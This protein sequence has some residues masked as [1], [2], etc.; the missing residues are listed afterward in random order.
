MSHMEKIL[1][2]Q[3]SLYYQIWNGSHK[4]VSKIAKLR[5][6]RRNKQMMLI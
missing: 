6:Y 5:K 2:N 1:Y 3:V 4:S